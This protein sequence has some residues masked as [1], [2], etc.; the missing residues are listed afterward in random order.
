MKRILVVVVVGI[1]IALFIS[2]VIV[3]LGYAGG[4]EDFKAM[5]IEERN[6]LGRPEIVVETATTVV[7]I[8]ALEHSMREF[9][10]NKLNDDWKVREI[11]KLEDSTKSL[12]HKEPS[13]RLKKAVS[14]YGT[15]N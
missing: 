13:E 1:V 3:S 12:W 10:F 4:M 11:Y 5:M 8:F 14:N 9:R 2:L 6:E 7:V 15:T